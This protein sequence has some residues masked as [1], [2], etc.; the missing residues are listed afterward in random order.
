MTKTQQGALSG[1]A[2]GAGAGLGISAL[3][4]GSLGV[5]ALIGGGL[6]AVAGGLYGNQKG[7]H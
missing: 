7:G 1:G 5:G 2:I 6:G 3:T 4:G